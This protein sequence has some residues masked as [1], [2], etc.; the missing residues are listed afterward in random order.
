[1]FSEILEN[2]IHY[3]QNCY[4]NEASNMIKNEIPSATL[5]TGTVPSIM[6]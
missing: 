4:T 6:S 1:V 3:V 5:L 2:L